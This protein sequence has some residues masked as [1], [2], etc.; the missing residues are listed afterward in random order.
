M[1]NYTNI[2]YFSGNKKKK[3][4]NSF[5]LDTFF[6]RC[7]YGTQLFAQV[8]AASHS[9]HAG[10]GSPQKNHY[11]GNPESWLVLVASAQIPSLACKPYIKYRLVFPMLL[12][13]NLLKPYWRANIIIL[14][15]TLKRHVEITVRKWFKLY[16][17]SKNYKK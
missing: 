2:L 12:F 7:L 13:F 3:W 5:V 4:I 1:D 10:G 11:S 16:W 17:R 14:F 9:A 15:T 8:S 6:D